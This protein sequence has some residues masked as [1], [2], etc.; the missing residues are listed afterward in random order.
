MVSFIFLFSPLF[1]EEFSICLVF[2]RWVVQ[3]PTR[4]VLYLLPT[5]GLPTK[6]LRLMVRKSPC[7][8]GAVQH[9]V[10]GCVDFRQW[11]AYRMFSRSWQLKHF[12]MFIPTW[13]DDSQFDDHIFQV[14]W[15]HL[16]FIDDLSVRLFH[17]WIV[18]FVVEVFF[19]EGAVGYINQ[20]VKFAEA[21]AH[22]QM[23]WDWPCPTKSL[24]ESR[25]A[26]QNPQ[27]YW[28]GSDSYYSMVPAFLQMCHCCMWIY[29][30]LSIYTIVLVDTCILHQRLQECQL[31]K[32]QKGHERNAR[33]C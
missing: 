28:V 4:L 17:Q 26:V 5:R 9:W 24:R 12:F 3:P 19:V 25:G 29:L 8:E 15:N 33:R 32:L 13:G 1:G 30:P 6:I 7:G 2:F 11:M 23:R 10:N 22:L 20:K 31:S 14:G 27:I 16:V 21:D 18:F